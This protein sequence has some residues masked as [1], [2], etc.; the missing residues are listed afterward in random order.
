MSDIVLNA[1][2]SILAAEAALD[3]WDARPSI[4]LIARRGEDF[5]LVPVELNQVWELSDPATVLA[6]IAVAVENRPADI[7]FPAVLPEGYV[8]GGTAMMTEGWGLD[9]KGLTDAEIDA[10]MELAS[11]HDLGEHPNRV[12]VKMLAAVDV[13][14]VHYIAHFQRGDDAPSLV[15]QSDEN[16]ELSGRIYEGLTR[17]LAALHDEPLQPDTP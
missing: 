13:E 4:G 1:L 11:T 14:G 3:Q 10:A 17:L 12:E 15:E 6:V 7:P 16:K 8:L 9:L 5:E 2:A